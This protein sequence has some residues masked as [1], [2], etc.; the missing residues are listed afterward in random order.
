M[1]AYGITDNG[2]TRDHNEDS[3]LCNATPVGQLPNLLAVADGMGGHKSGEVAS[4][5]ALEFFCDF[6][7]SR[8]AKRG[9]LDFIVEAALYANE[10]VYK[11]SQ[12]DFAMT[13]MGTTFSACVLADQ[14]IYI[15]H[16]GDSRVYYF[17]GDHA[18][19]LT[20]DHS[21]VQSLVK[22]GLIT[23]DDAQTHP[24]KNLLTR[25]LGVEPYENIDALVFEPDAPGILLLC[26]DGLT[27][28]VP[29]N[30]LARI[31]QSDFSIEQKAELMV[32]EANNNGGQDNI[33]VILAE[34][35]R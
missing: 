11:M 24:K 23:Q 27:N 9:L 18:R 7:S 29:D 17:T 10:S 34:L 30:E 28:M 13:G 6:V 8:E 31:A 14:K 12:S 15:A 3:F 1:N 19:R 26:S 32:Q 5:K 35:G 20:E 25:V 33:T 21:Y 4:A 16:V 22:A 2:R